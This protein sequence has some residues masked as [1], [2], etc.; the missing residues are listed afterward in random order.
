MTASSAK[1]AQRRFDFT[2][3][4]DA[5]MTVNAL[6][7]YRTL[8]HFVRHRYEGNEYEEMRA[9]FARL[10]EEDLQEDFGVALAGREVI[11]VGGGTGRFSAYFSERS[12]ARCVNAELQD[13]RAVEDRFGRTLQA[14]GT[15]LPVQSERFDFALCRGVIEHVPRERQPAMIQECYRV[16]KPGGV[17]L[18]NTQPWYAPFAGHQLRPF[19]IL[20]FPLA[21]RLSSWT[22]SMPIDGDSLADIDP[23]LYPI[24]MRRLDAMI[25]GSGFKILG[26][27]DYHFR[28]H[29]VTRVPL[30][31]EVLTQSITY[32]LQKE[33]GA[34]QS[35]AA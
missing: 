9:Y 14:D 32:I 18:L 35:V 12:G 8:W 11:E 16:L 27:R 17:C 1:S 15:R 22:R 19:H 5:R 10:L 34:E 29:A 26:T 33:Q 24:T 31:R 6:Q 25:R 2:G 23:P 21:K 30:L 13:M 4:Q 3:A 7:H 28:V 20:P